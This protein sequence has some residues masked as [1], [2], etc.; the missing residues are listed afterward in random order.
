MSC[1]EQL[2]FSLKAWIHGGV[3]I[4]VPCIKT[5]KQD[6]KIGL[7]L[8]AVKKLKLTASKPVVWFIY[9]A[10]TSNVELFCQVGLHLGKEHSFSAFMF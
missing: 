2:Q 6:Y 8:S 1:H 5:V 7:V 10:K 3:W 9:M 4:T